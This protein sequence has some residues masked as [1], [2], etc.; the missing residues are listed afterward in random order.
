LRYSA[1]G[2]LHKSDLYGLVT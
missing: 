2:F 1:K